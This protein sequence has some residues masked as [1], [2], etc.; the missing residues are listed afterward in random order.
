MYYHLATTHIVDNV[1]CGK[2]FANFYA[3]R[4]YVIDTW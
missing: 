4:F 2:F 3:M 1:F